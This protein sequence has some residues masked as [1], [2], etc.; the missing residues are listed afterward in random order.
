MM[1]VIS[2][3]LTKNE[4]FRLQ[5]NALPGALDYEQPRRQ[6]RN[7]DGS[8]TQFNEHHKE[9]WLCDGYDY[10]DSRRVVPPRVHPGQCLRPW[11]R[12]LLARASEASMTTFNGMMCRW[13]SRGVHLKDGPHSYSTH[14]GWAEDTVIGLLAVGP[15]R[16]YHI[17]GIPWFYGRGRKEVVS[18]NIPLEEGMLV[19]L[20]GPLKDKFLYSQPRDEEMLPERIQ[21]TLQLHADSAVVMGAAQAEGRDWTEDCDGVV[22]TPPQDFTVAPDPSPLPV[23][24]AAPSA[25]LASG[26]S[27]WR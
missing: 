2:N 5:Q 15:T 13:E 9:A 26:G 16:L 6:V 17:H 3:F 11:A 8:F 10:R 12:D 20:G 21:F 4:V 22:A 23:A 24:S 25:T 7:P 19:V 14:H 1:F 27:R 18:V